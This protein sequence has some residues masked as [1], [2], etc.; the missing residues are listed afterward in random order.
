VQCLY[1]GEGEGRLLQYNHRLC[2]H[3]AQ[4]KPRESS[5][6]LFL[7]YSAAAFCSE[8][9]SLPR[10]GSERHSES[11]FLFFVARKG[12]VAIS[13]PQNNLEWN[14]ENFLLFWLHGT[15]IRD[16]LF[17]GT[18]GIPS[19]IT[20][21]SVYSVFRGIIFFVGNSQPYLS[22]HINNGDTACISAKVTFYVSVY[23]IEKMT[24]IEV[25]RFI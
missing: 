5:L 1:A 21:C 14:S 10:N 6:T 23:K 13:I 19:E 24:H 20:I 15:E 2:F 16:F 25:C 9:V 8:L 12:R 3:P 11:L 22:F 4:Q 18:T 17:R 7:K